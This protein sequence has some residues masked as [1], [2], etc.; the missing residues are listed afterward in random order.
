M[1][2]RTR[3][4]TG[5]APGTISII[6]G[7]LATCV[8]G[9]L[10][11]RIPALAAGALLVLALLS[12]TFTAT[13]QQDPRF[14]SQTNFRV[15]NDAFWTFFQSRG[16]VRTFGYPVSRSF[17]LDGFTVQIFQRIVMQLQPDGSVG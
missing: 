8:V 10:P 7:Q 9:S 2:A 11:C 16:G 17:K 1:L 5:S 13:A 12:P 4:S 15:D 14:F 3:A 6:Q